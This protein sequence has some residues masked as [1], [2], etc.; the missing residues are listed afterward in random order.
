MMIRRISVCVHG[1]N[2]ASNDVAGARTGGG[3]R[4]AVSERTP[5]SLRTKKVA[6]PSAIWS[7]PQATSRCRPSSVDIERQSA[8]D[9]RPHCSRRSRQYFCDGATESDDELRRPRTG[10]QWRCPLS[11]TCAPNGDVVV[12]ECDIQRQTTETGNT[13]G[14][15]CWVEAPDGRQYVAAYRHQRRQT[16]AAA[17]D[18]AH[19]P[20]APDA[21]RCGRSNCILALIVAFVIIIRLIVACMR[22]VTLG[23]FFLSSA[24]SRT[25]AFE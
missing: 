5:S 1:R 17:V 16:T 2:D 8:V 25:L 12:V 15:E 4:S 13:P 24:G 6:K 23:N 9:K 18:K 3:G 22:L 11:G 7:V 10:D 20:P 21:A 19:C 14:D